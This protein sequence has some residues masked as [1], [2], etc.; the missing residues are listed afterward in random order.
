[1]LGSRN[2]RQWSGGGRLGRLRRTLSRLN[3][4]VVIAAAGLTLGMGV[5][6]PATIMASAPPT[7][8][9]SP[10]SGQPGDVLSITGR[11]FPR[12]A[13]AVLAWNGSVAGMPQA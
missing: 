13:T 8:S 5:A 9:S 10:S 7:L 6:A 3:R 2:S 4:T 11:G 1:M 12:L